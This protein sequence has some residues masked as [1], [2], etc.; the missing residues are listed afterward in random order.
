[1]VRGAAL[2]VAVGGA[3]ALVARVVDA[4]A[5]DDT[6]LALPLLLVTLAGLTAAGWMAARR[7]GRAPLTN[8]AVAALVAVAVLVG[9]ALVVRLAAGDDV[10][11]GFLVIW[12][13]LALACGLVGGLAA[14][15]GPRRGAD[16][17]L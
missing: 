9:V 12:A 5:D 3:A 4:V 2:G 6:P 17:R 10:R 7:C 14:L 11:W 8:A 15:R 16:S 13:P 1:V